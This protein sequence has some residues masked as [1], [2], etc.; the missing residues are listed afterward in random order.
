MGC[1]MPYTLEQKVWAYQN[2]EAY[3][4]Y[5]WYSPS[6]Y[7]QPFVYPEIL[8]H[9][10]DPQQFPNVQLPEAASELSMPLSNHGEPCLVQVSGA[11][12]FIFFMFHHKSP[13]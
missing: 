8:R 6:P 3:H 2:R 12:I 9:L 13:I 7:D 1:W 11:L 5:G 10:S 4:P